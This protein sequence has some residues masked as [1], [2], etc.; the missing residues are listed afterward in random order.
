M[1]EKSSVNCDD[2][3]WNEMMMSEENRKSIKNLWILDGEM[4]VVYFGNIFLVHWD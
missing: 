2:D 1:M 3:V 4:T